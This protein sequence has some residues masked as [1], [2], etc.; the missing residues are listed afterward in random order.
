MHEQLLAIEESIFQALEIP[1]RVIDTAT[2]DLGAPAYRKYD[3]EGWMP[4]RGES[5]DYGELTST[6]NCTDYQARRLR[7]R[8]RRKGSKK[9]EHVHMLNGT[10]ISMA[11]ALLTLMENFQQSDGSILVPKALQPY[12]GFDR[13]G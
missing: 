13:I 11:R 3:I 8:F 1:Y 10:A 5:G 6:S 7:I 4:S 12:T 2:G 9:V